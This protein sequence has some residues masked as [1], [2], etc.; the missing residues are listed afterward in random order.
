MSKARLQL[1]R[2]SS[3]GRA[4]AIVGAQYAEIALPLLLAAGH[5][6][7]RRP[8]PAANRGTAAARPVAA[9]GPPLAGGA[10]PGRPRPALRLALPRRCATGRHP[11]RPD[12]GRRAPV[13]HAASRPPPAQLL[14]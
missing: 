14:I 5:H 2:P 7:R 10:D 6:P 4:Y 13:G 3:L 1:S 12:D 11:H 8:A 9:A